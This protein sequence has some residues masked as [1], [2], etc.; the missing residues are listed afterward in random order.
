[1]SR[2]AA[3]RRSAPLLAAFLL[4]AGFVI[5]RPGA[6][7]KDAGEYDALARSIRG[8][9]FE[10]GGHPSMLREPGYPAFRA[11]VFSVADHL[12]AVRW[13][14]VLLFVA[15]AWLVRAAL[16]EIDAR[17]AATGAWA[18]AL[19]Y[20][21]AV[22]VARHLLE[23]LAAAEVALLVWLAARL[24]VR[25]ASWGRIAAFSS[26]GAALALTRF[27]LVPI[28]LLLL[29][30]M[31]IAWRPRGLRH[32]V[33]RIAVAGGLLA[34]LVA[35][36]V[37]RNGMAFGVWSVAGRTGVQA[38]A[39]AYK[40]AAPW[41]RFVASA[42]SVLVGRSAL[43]AVVPS[44]APIVF[45]QWN[46]VWARYAALSVGTDASAADSRL[47]EES[48]A[49]I[50]STPGMAMRAALWSGIDTARLLALPSPFS[51]EFGI[52]NMFWPQAEKGTLG[53]LRIAVLLLAHAVQAAWWAGM[54]FGAWEGFRRYRARFVPGWI[55]LAVVAAHLP[56]DNIVRYAAPVHPWLAFLAAWGW[57]RFASLHLRRLVVVRR[58]AAA[59]FGEGGPDLS[60]TPSSLGE[61]GVAV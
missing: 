25:G 59:F 10:I 9:R 36:W 47:Q 26:A 3:L 33:P 4:A 24:L 40:A 16:R 27:S 56:A 22:Y 37:V 20:G 51:Q 17:L 15:T 61:T 52:E 14:Q 55:L 12:E 44:A 48:F 53:P 34:A 35:P 46:W 30:G 6:L 19:S 23:T 57:M 50:L 11:A 8:G 29:A 38:A 39:R 60:R 58:I 7:S 43:R 28:P 32:L 54:A 21:L 41:S 13:I 31:A 5:S 1:M 42:V 45:D 18:A 49:Q 2:G